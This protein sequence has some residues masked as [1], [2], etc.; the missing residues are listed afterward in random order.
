MHKNRQPQSQGISFE[1]THQHQLSKTQVIPQ[2]PYPHFPNTNPNP[3]PNPTKYTITPE[4]KKYSSI[5]RSKKS[6][7]NNNKPKSTMN[8][9]RN[10]GR[11]RGRS[12]GRGRGRSQGRG[13]GRGRGRSQGIN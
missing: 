10:R 12:H 9:M 3:N 6:V 5:Y 1:K 8:N 2:N 11:G 7:K 13:R 4:L